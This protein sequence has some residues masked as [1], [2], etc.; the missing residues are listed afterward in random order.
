MNVLEEIITKR[1]EYLD[2]RKFEA[3]REL[4]G[5]GIPIGK[6]KEIVEDV[7]GLFGRVI[8]KPRVF[9]EAIREIKEKGLSEE[10]ALE[11]LKTSLNLPYNQEPSTGLLEL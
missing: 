10:R 7:Y 5:I 6:R 2:K 4:N 3:Y 8:L 11:Y 1:R 9:S